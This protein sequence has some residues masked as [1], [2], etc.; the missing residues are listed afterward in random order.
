MMYLRAGRKQ[1]ALAHIPSRD[2]ADKEFLQQCM[3]GTTNYFNIRQIPS[4]G[5]RATQTVAQFQAA[6]SRLREKAQ[7]ELRG[8]NFCNQIYG[9]GDIE[10]FPGGNEFTPGTQVLVYAEVSNF[11]S[12]LAP[13][14]R[15]H[16]KLKPS[17]EILRPGGQGPLIEQKNVAPIEDACNNHRQDF[18]FFIKLSLPEQIAQG[19]YVLRLTLEDELSR[20]I[21][22]QTLNFT[23][24]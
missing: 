16:S 7:L 21:A 15:Y 9:F 22:V 23:V 3:W 24:K 5:D 17:Y 13:D 4:A 2:P 14:G 19:P 11:K 18:Y 10:K 6:S 20:K 1:R 8:L 12:D